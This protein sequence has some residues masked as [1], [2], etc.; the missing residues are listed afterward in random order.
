[1]SEQRWWYC[2]KHLAVEPN[3]ACPNKRRLG[4]YA[5]RDEAAAA[6][7]TAAERNEEWEREDRTD[8]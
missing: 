3:D 1:M 5:T 6:L 4:P 7:E 2:L 8:S